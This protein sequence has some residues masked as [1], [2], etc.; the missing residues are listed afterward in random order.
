MNGLGTA[1]APPGEPAHS[2]RR[3]LVAGSVGN[4]NEWYEFGIY[5]FFATLIAA[6]FFSPTHSSD[7]ESLINAYASFAITFFFRPLGAV[8]FGRIGDRVGR[9]PTLI[10]ALLL[11]SFSTTAIGIL[12]TY[13]QVGGLAPVLITLV[14]VVQG[15]SAGGEFGGAVSVMTEF[16]PRGRRGL[17]GA[18]QSLSVALG[19]LAGAASAAAVVTF[20]SADALQAW[21]WRVPFLAAFP[22]GL[23]A[24]WLRLRLEETPSFRHAQAE[25]AR[26]VAVRMRP[27]AG[28]V[29]ATTA[30]GIARVMGWSAAGY[31]LLVVLPSYLHA[32]LNTGLREALMATVL[33]NLGFALS[34]LP[35][36]AASDRY[37]RRA[38]MLAG[39]A[40][41]I[42]LALPLY[43][44][45]QSG[46]APLGAKVLALLVMGAAVG[47]VAGPGPA[48]L[49][50]MFPTSVRYTGLGLAYALSNAVFA[51]SA[52]L[53][54]TAAIKIT[55]NGNIPAYYVIA[56]GSISLI[57]LAT[58]GGDAHRHA[59]RE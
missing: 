20:V 59:L 50:E 25:P 45:L 43:A 18:W 21:G 33:A 9:R 27:G 19:L 58:S 49:S 29:L 38:V 41:V 48:M 36:G 6:T 22:L 31:T 13:A 12:P 46:H 4:F 23:I 47:L 2:A 17:Y 30:L 26:G 52:G 11:M 16:A 56:T 24:L 7:F 53:I 39:M 40:I 34:I 10:T 57:A 14:R 28:E 1:N 55:G 44:L 54:I 5:G 37:G 15:L 51:G 35:A 3:A 8:L 32:T 42:M